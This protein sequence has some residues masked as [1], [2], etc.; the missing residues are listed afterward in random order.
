MHFEWHYIVPENTLYSSFTFA[1][2]WSFVC[3][4]R[5]SMAMK[6]NLLFYQNKQHCWNFALCTKYICPLLSFIFNIYKQ[7]YHARFTHRLGQVITFMK[8]WYTRL[9]PINVATW[10]LWEFKIMANIYLIFIHIDSH[11]R[12]IA[13]IVSRVTIKFI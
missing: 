12:R 4:Q 2:W 11:T 9:F 6:K 5:I 10:T 13:L 7:R 1:S 8:S 3:S